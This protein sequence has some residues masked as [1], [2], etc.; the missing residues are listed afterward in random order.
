MHNKEINLTDLTRPI[1]NKQEYEAA[2]SRVEIVMSA[3]PGSPDEAELDKLAC[4]IVA[5]EDIHHPIPG[6]DSAAPEVF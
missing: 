2:L 6:P 1:K 3:E 5:Y 4:L